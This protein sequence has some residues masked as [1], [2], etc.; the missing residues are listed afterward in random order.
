MFLSLAKNCDHSRKVVAQAARDIPK[1][2]VEC[3]CTLL[4][5]D[6]LLEDLVQ[7]AEDIFDAMRASCFAKQPLTF[8]EV[9]S[10]IP[11]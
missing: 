4:V 11:S 9:N 3:G 10:C 8:H 7:G 5:Q 1:L 2:Q 6:F